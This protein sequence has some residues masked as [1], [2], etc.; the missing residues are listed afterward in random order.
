MTE[1]QQVLA[2]LSADFATMSQQLTRASA[3]LTQLADTLGAGAAAVTAQPAAQPLPWTYAQY[4]QYYA[5]YP[6]AQYPQAQYPQYAQYQQHAPA[7][8]P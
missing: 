6:Q 2:R 8:Q 3:E 7:P 1:P 4:Q 5:Q